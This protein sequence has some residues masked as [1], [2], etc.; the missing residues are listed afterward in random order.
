M[1]LKIF[2]F[3]HSFFYQNRHLSILYSN[4]I[5]ILAIGGSYE[6]GETFF[7]SIMEETGTSVTWPSKLKI[8]AKSKKD[9]HV[10]VC[11][12]V[13]IKTKFWLKL[14]SVLYNIYYTRIFAA[15][16][17]CEK[18]ERT[19]FGEVRRPKFPSNTE[20]GRSSHGTLTRH[21]KR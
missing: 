19:Y 9:P 3:W 14:I 20:N 18:G 12:Q 4:L 11:G 13:R 6:N 2:S 8:G 1:K 7:Q 15:G 5:F 21:R 10:K 16:R 17:R